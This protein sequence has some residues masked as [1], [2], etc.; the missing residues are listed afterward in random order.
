LNPMKKDPPVRYR[1]WKDAR[2]ICPRF[3]SDDIVNP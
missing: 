1:A 2:S 3:F